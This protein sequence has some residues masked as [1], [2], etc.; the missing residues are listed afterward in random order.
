MYAIAD[1]CW[2]IELH[3]VQW[4]ARASETTKQR[5]A[6][7][8]TNVYTPQG[9][10]QLARLLQWELSSAGLTGGSNQGAA[11]EASEDNEAACMY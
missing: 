10:W 7:H 3:S 9:G 6:M 1:G 2:Y 4:E 8:C 5:I 11:A